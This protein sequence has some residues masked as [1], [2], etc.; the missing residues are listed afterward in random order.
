M[1]LL[2]SELN[3]N[4][5]L[6]L[7]VLNV[8]PQ[9][10]F[11]RLENPRTVDDE[12]WK[13]WTMKCY[14]ESILST[15]D[16]KY[17][18]IKNDDRVAQAMLSLSIDILTQHLTLDDIYTLIHGLKGK[19]IIGRNIPHALFEQISDIKE[20]LVKIVYENNQISGTPVTEFIK[21][22]IMRGFLPQECIDSIL[23][24]D[25]DIDHDEN[26]ELVLSV[27]M[28]FRRFWTRSIASWH[29]SS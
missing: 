3:S 1:A 29:R 28:M 26:D 20:W 9:E 23:E 8:G 19:D 5:D 14:R 17:F 22:A 15:N 4:S 16:K 21:V 25:E 10:T 2:L 18:F 13:A 7:S 27:M 6:D 24:A 11:S 12:R